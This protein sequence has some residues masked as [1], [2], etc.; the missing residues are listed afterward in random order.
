MLHVKALNGP[1]NG[2]LVARR[3]D[4]LWT[5]EIHFAPPKKPWETIVCWHLQ[6][7]QGVLGAGFS[8]IRIEKHLGAASKVPPSWPSYFGR[9]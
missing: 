9:M 3:K 4:L 5:Y 6:T 2:T 8:S 1:L 7:F